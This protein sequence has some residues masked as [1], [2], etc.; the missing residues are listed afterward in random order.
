MRKFLRLVI[1]IV[2]TIGEILFEWGIALGIS[3]LIFWVFNIDFTSFIFIVAI[4]LWSA[5]EIIKAIIEDCKYG[6]RD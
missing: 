3:A 1:G 2:A 4:L 5:W 6:E